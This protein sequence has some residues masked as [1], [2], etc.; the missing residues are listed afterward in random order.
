MIS[1][2]II[3]NHTTIS[4]ASTKV[5]RWPP[6]LRCILQVTLLAHFVQNGPP[7]SLAILLAKHSRHF[8]A[9]L[10]VFSLR[11]FFAHL[12]TP[13]F[14]MIVNLHAIAGKLDSRPKHKTNP[15]RNSK[16][17]ATSTK[18]QK[19]TWKTSRST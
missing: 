11:L 8:C 3:R 2:K 7:A 19:P 13:C 1:P 5:L 18:H 15:K 17:K 4:T 6:L 16:E 14:W 10:A 12:T 9:S